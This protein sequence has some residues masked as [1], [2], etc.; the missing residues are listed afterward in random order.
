[1]QRALKTF[2]ALV[3]IFCLFLCFHSSSAGEL[4]NKNAMST[5]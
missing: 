1:M 3:I 2:Y 5:F 4:E